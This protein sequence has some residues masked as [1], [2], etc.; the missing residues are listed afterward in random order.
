MV[1]LYGALTFLFIGM[2]FVLLGFLEVIVVAA[3]VPWF[4]LLVGVVLLAIHYATHP[5]HRGRVE[6]TGRHPI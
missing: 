4:I 6:G 2:L 3:H 5:D 1:L